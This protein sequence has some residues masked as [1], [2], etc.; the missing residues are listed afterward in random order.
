M[1]AWC[2]QRSEEDIRSCRTG[3]MRTVVSHHVDAENQTQFLYKY[4]KCPLL[5]SYLSNMHI[6][7]KLFI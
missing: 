6:L 1:H 2:S 7:L 4:T 3:V 5:L